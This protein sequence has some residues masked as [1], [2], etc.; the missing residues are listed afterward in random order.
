MGPIRIERSP[1]KVVNDTIQVK[2]GQATIDV[3]P[4]FDPDLLR[5]VVTA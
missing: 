5:D 3:K 2:V 1:P 4:G